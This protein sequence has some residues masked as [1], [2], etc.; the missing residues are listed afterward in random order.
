[1]E[2]FKTDSLSAYLPLKPGKY[3]T[4][5]LDSTVFTQLGRGE[6]IHSYQ[7]KNIVD[8]PIVDNLGR[9]GFRIFRFIRDTAGLNSWASAGTYYIIPLRNEIEIVDNNLRVLKLVLP[10]NEG[11]KWKGNSYVGTNPFVSK[12]DY[13]D[14]NHI[15]ISD[16][17]FTYESIGKS[18]VLNGQTI[19]DII[20]MKG[21]DESVNVP[22][23]DKTAFASRTYL[24][25]QYA[26]NIGLVYQELVMWE[27]QPNPGGTAFKVGF[28]VK[29]SMIDHN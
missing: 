19:P 14:D 13:S 3:I 8:S 18:L 2:T 1:V 11:K 28:G 25:D 4:Y 15:R 24:I 27:Y 12:Y 22:V 26:K 9:N 23:A 20:T 29:R 5:R 16:W 21:P 6:E 17:D 7:E 10:L